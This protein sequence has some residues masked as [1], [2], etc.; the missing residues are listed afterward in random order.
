MERSPYFLMVKKFYVLVSCYDIIKK[1]SE[2]SEDSIAE[3][4]VKLSRFAFSNM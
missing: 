3:M 1:L 4:P 2:S